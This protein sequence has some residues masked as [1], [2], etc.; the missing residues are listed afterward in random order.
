MKNVYH[1]FQTKST[2][3]ND[4]TTT[5]LHTIARKKMMK[6][7]LQQVIKKSSKLYHISTCIYV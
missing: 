1:V 2:E 3:R 7:G 6:T 4:L 5:G